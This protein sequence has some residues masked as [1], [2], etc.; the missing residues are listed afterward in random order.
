YSEPGL[1]IRPLL[2]A[3]GRRLDNIYFKSKAG[4][5]HL[6]GSIFHGYQEWAGAENLADYGAR[7]AAQLRTA[8]PS[9]ISCRTQRDEY[10]V[11]V[12]FTVEIPAQSDLSRY[13]RNIDSLTLRNIADS[14]GGASHA[15]VLRAS[16]PP[17]SDDRGI[18]WWIRYV[19][20]PLLGSATAV[21]FVALLIKL[22]A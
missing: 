11:T 5:Q 7:L 4:K 16:A 18:K 15:F 8:L 13:L 10:G 17:G 22:A 12:W 20:V 3:G 21:A 6:T 9:C 2:K 19:V 1:Q 14:R